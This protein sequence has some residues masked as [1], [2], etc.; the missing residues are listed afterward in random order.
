[1][2]AFKG[3]LVAAD[4]MNFVQ[5]TY[6]LQPD[7]SNMSTG[8]TYQENMS[9]KCIL[10]HTP[11]LYSKNGINRGLAIILTF[12]PKHRLW[13]LEAVLTCTP[14]LCFEQKKITNVS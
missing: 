6:S 3:S 10:P 11:L 14:N 1:M 7:I 13:V 9:A 5:Y 8:I 12:D 2:P 4:H